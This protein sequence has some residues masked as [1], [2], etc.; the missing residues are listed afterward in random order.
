VVHG[1]FEPEDLHERIRELAGGAAVLS[2]AVAPV[3]F[4][5]L[6]RAPAETEPG[7]D[8]LTTREREIMSRIA[9]GRTNGEIAAE[10][11]LSEKTVKN[12]VN[13]I[14]AKLGAHSRTH[15][16]ALWLGS[17]RQP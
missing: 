11:V 14:Y 5:A 2:P 1:R 6:R 7:G 9:Q 16:T 8:E 15:A 17:G 10:L 3:I 4:E 13:R 12:H